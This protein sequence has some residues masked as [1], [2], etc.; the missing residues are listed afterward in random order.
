MERGRF[1]A[2]ENIALI[3]TFFVSDAFPLGYTF[4][5]PSFPLILPSFL[6]FSYSSSLSHSLLLPFKSKFLQPIFYG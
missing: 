3:A 2:H 6:S 1:S 5:S 4:P